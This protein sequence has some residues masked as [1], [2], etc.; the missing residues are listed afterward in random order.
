MGPLPIQK[1]QSA[2]KLSTG[3]RLVPTVWDTSQKPG[4]Q[5][6]TKGLTFSSQQLTVSLVC[7]G[8]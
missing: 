5:M 1:A 6:L 4:Q 2:E 8:P 7:H 3:G